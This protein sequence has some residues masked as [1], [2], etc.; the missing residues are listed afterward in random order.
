M[1]LVAVSR[2]GT[3][4]ETLRACQRFR[5]EHI[6]D[7]LTISCHPG[8][9]LSS[10][11][12]LNLVLPAAQEQSIAQTRAFSTLYLATVVLA[13][14]WTEEA[15]VFARFAPLP[16]AGREIL[17]RSQQFVVPVAQDDALDRFYVLGSG[18]RYGLAC[19]VSLKLKEMSLSHSEPFHVLEFRH[20]PQAMVTASTLIIGMVSQRNRDHER[21]VLNEMRLLGA[22]VLEIGYDGSDIVL[23]SGLDPSVATILYLLPGQMLAFERALHRGCDPDRPHNL[24]AVVTLSETA[25]TGL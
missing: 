23:N 1:L 15:D 7:I 2:S 21:T 20:G 18:A 17:S 5:A 14:L 8:T 22:R 25:A 6:G 9:E 24:R 11:G 4:T 16:A 13:L 19:E 10:Y 3:T 12:A